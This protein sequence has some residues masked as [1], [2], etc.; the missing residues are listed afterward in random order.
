MTWLSVIS[1]AVALGMDAFAVAIG[2]GSQRT[3][4]KPR[5]LLR[6]SFHFGLFQFMMPVIGWYAGST[7]SE[8]IKDY[9]HWIAM[10][11]LA[12]I[13]GKMIK[14]SFGGE[15]TDHGKTFDPTRGWTL[16]VLSVATSIDALM[17]GL[18][19]AFLEVPILIPVIVIGVVTFALSYLGFVF[20]S[21]MGMIFGK[22]IKAIGGLILI[23]IG[24][25]IVMEHML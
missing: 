10:G 5:P 1:I 23:L 12:V 17:V 14:E 21:R 22:K 8:Y 20:G 6:L 25:R 24:V 16:I 7:V 11:L 3:S 9:D 13:G 4:I 19:F 15:D 18:S 2:A